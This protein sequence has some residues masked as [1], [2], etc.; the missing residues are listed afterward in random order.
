MIEKTQES[1]KGLVLPGNKIIESNMQ[2]MGILSFGVPQMQAFLHTWTFLYR[3]Q[4]TAY[5]CTDLERACSTAWI[6]DVAKAASYDGCRHST[7]CGF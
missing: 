2:I 1:A 3:A 6:G 5:R 7:A 4:F